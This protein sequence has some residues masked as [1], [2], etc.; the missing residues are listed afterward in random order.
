MKDLSVKDTGSR[1][2]KHFNQFRKCSRPVCNKFLQ[3]FSEAAIATPAFPPPN[4]QAL[5][6]DAL[7]LSSLPIQAISLACVDGGSYKL[8]PSTQVYNKG[9]IVL[10]MHMNRHLD[11]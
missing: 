3:V 4:I 10:N 5:I 8:P 6:P 11:N 9:K 7:S 2:S 1:F